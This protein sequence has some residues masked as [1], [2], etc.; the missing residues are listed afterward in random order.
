MLIKTVFLKLLI[1]DYC[2]SKKIEYNLMNPFASHDVT[3][4]KH[5]LKTTNFYSLF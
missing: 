2:F 5:A 1:S 3:S 4:I